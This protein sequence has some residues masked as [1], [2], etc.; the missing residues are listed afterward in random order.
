MYINPINKTTTM[1]GLYDDMGLTHDRVW[2]MTALVAME[3]GN[4]PAQAIEIADVVVAAWQARFAP[5]EVP[6]HD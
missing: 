3:Q 2:L 1:A 4:R 6:S 5:K